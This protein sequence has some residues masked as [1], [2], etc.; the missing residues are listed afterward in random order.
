MLANLFR[1]EPKDLFLKEDDKTAVRIGSDWKGRGI[2][3]DDSTLRQHV[4]VLG[5]NHASRTDLLLTMFESALQAGSGG[6]Y[7][8]ASGDSSVL[9]RI[10]EAAA[11]HGRSD[12]LQVLDLRHS[13]EERVETSARINPFEHASAARVTQIVYDV[14][15]DGYERGIVLPLIHPVAKA[16]C[17]LRDNK[18]ERFNGHTLIDVIGDAGLMKLASRSELPADIRKL[19][20]GC[21]DG[22]GSDPHEYAQMIITLGLAH[23]LDVLPET[24]AP[25]DEGLDLTALRADRKYLVVL[26]PSLEVCSD[27]VISSARL[28]IASFKASI[29]DVLQATS[30]SEAAERITF[31]KTLKVPFM[32]VFDEAPWYMPHQNAI[33]MS[34]ARALGISF[35]M[36]SSDVYAV[37]WPQMDIRGDLFSNA[38][39]TI[40]FNVDSWNSRLAGL[41]AESRAGRS[42]DPA[43]RR[44]ATRD[45]PFGSPHALISSMKPNEFLAVS[46]GQM[47]PGH[48]DYPPR[49][50]NG[51]QS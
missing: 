18:G 15:V 30:Q 11:R 32:C 39:T 34:Q 19:L 50:A 25:D 51:A 24:F 2:G 40:L 12:E 22:L 6:I 4:L 37:S 47:V 36:G 46:C 23:S 41:I 5:S 49:P 8:S 31:D 20:A 16:L 13:P 7:V 29:E 9:D 45:R 33:M 14:C 21:V 42:G 17:W 3:L 10:T 28:F 44:V 35:V 43:F 38:L 48:R 1:R 26:T 27:A